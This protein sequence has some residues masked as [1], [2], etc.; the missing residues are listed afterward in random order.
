MQSKPVSGEPDGLAAVLA[1]E[2]RVSNLRPLAAASHRG[3][4]ILVRAPRIVAGLDQ[5]D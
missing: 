5:R 1:A 2:P 4:P 3:E